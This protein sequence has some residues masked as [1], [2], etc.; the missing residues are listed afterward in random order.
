MGCSPRNLA[1]LGDCRR[2]LNYAPV[3]IGTLNCDPLGS[4]RASARPPTWTALLERRNAI[5]C[6]AEKEVGGSVLRTFRE[7]ERGNFPSRSDFVIG[8]V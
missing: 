1:Q 3:V 6:S 4:E 7:D 8:E 5:S 2:L